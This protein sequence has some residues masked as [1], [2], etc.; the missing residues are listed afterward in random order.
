MDLTCSRP[1]LGVLGGK[2]SN[3]YLW[4]LE[5]R[6]GNRARNAAAKSSLMTAQSGVAVVT[7]RII[8]NA[9]L[10]TSKKYER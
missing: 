3:Y 5:I 6:L 1:L 2:T 10:G 9:R 4:A 8:E 7:R